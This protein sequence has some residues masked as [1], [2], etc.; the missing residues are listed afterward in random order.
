MIYLGTPIGT[1]KIRGKLTAIVQLASCVLHIPYVFFIVPRF[2]LLI[3]IP[4]YSRV[5]HS[6]S[7]QMSAVPLPLTDS[8]SVKA[9]LL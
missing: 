3:I 2:Y 7:R 1:R 5:L 9:L 6:V 8:I 4:Q